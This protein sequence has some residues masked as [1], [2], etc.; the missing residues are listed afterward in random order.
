VHERFEHLGANDVTRYT[1]PS[2]NALNFVIR[3]V[4]AGGVTTSLRVDTHGKSLS[5]LL[6]GMEVSDGV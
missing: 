5:Y 6:A 1:V 4:L 2:T 3:G